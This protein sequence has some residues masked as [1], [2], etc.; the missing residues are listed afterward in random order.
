MEQ[1]THSGLPFPQPNSLQII[2]FRGAGRS[3]LSRPWALVLPVGGRRNTRRTRYTHRPPAR[4]ISIPSFTHI[5]VNPRLAPPHHCRAHIQQHRV[6]ILLHVLHHRRTRI[7]CAALPIPRLHLTLQ[8]RPPPYPGSLTDVQSLL[9]HIDRLPDVPPCPHPTASPTHS[10]TALLPA[11]P[12]PSDSDSICV[13]FG[14]YFFLNLLQHPLAFEQIGRKH[15][16]LKRDQRN[17]RL[18]SLWRRSLLRSRSLGSWL[19]GRSRSRSSRTWS[20]GS[21]SLRQSDGGHHCRAQ[22]SHC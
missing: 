7:F 20:R 5:T 16:I 9:F 4:E 10:G 13:F 3:E 1:E 6:A 15:R 22:R 21:R 8:S 11:C 18:H 14:S 17:L 2:V 19:R 12:L